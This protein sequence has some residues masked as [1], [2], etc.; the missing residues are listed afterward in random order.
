MKNENNEEY[1]RFNRRENDWCDRRIIKMKII[2]N[3]L[4]ERYLFHIYIY[5][6]DRDNDSYISHNN[7]IYYS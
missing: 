5:S 3:N 2:L 7:T 4:R 6:V 1:K